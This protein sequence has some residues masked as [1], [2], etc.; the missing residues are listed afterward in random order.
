MIEDLIEDLIHV[1][2]V[3][4]SFSSEV[5]Q[6]FKF[7]LMQHLSKFEIERL[8]RIRRNNEYL[9]ELGLDNEKQ[10]VRKKRRTRK[11]KTSEEPVIRRR[12]YVFFYSEF[13]PS[14]IH[15]NYHTHLRNTRNSGPDS[16]I[17]SLQAVW[18]RR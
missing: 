5:I 10:F 7:F 1:Q 12:S 2:D 4:G 17:F 3:C 15:P 16:R 9:K 11:K 8:E 18:R 13:T 6:I 14:S